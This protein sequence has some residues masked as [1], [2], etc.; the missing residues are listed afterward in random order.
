MDNIRRVIKTI[1]IGFVV[2][3]FLLNTGRALQAIDLCK[4][5]LISLVDNKPQFEQDH[6][7]K[8]LRI[9]YKVVFSAYYNICDFKNAEK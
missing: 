7:T 8:F 6:F 9:F 3:R 1:C 4:E 5:C 2:A